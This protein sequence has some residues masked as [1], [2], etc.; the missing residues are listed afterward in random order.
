M[1][2][3]I[4]IHSNPQPW[5][6]PTGDY[7]AAYQELPAP[8]RQRLGAEFEQVM[9]ELHANGE[10]VG[11]EALGDPA[12]ARLYRWRDGAPLASD[13][14]Y[15][16]AKEHLAGFFLVDVDSHARA[17]EIAARFTGPGETV[18]LRPTMWP[19]GDDQ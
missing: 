6:H 1:K 16:E 12:N 2:Y 18:E 5:G 11:G 13:G 4:L 14:P 7:L 15:S 10:L 8:V 19:G 17:E 3:V 9:A